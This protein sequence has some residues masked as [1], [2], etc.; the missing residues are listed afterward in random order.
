MS[1][2]PDDEIAVLISTVEFSKPGKYFRLVPREK[3]LQFAD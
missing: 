1:K 3:K 2:V